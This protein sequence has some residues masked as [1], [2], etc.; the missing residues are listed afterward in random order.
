MKYN[1]FLNAFGVVS[2]IYKSEITQSLLNVYYTLLK[3]YDINDFK[4]VCVEIM[5]EYKY[6]TLPKPAE[7][8]ERLEP[9]KDDLET[10]AIKAYDLAIRAMARFGVYESVSFSDKAI[11]ATIESLG[12][13][14][15]FGNRENND[16]L[17][18]NF[19]RIY[20]AYAKNTDHAPKCLIGLSDYENLKNG[21]LQD[22]EI[23]VLF[24]DNHAA[25]KIKKSELMPNSISKIELLL[26]QKG[27][28]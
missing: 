20:K 15:E 17:R 22:D 9:P 28:I 6:N 18:A 4:R 7:F 19:I 16:F 14:V 13:W 5:R 2:E 11:N 10:K 8:I 12:G 1:E 23:C 3:Q 26:S 25:K 24:I 21:Y 27:L